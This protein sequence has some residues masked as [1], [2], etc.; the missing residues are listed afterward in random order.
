M[1]LVTRPLFRQ[2]VHT[3][4]RVGEPLS[5]MRTRWRFGSKRRFVATIECERLWP[6]AGFFP[7]TEQTLDIGGGSY[8]RHAHGRR[9]ARTARGAAGIGSRS[10][11]TGA[12]RFAER[13]ERRTRSGSPG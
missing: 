8:Q 4:A 12:T 7:Q 10:A 13:S 9:P 11:T 5:R 2:R 6:N 1:A 3:Y